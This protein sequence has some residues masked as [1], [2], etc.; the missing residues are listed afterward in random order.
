MSGRVRTSW[1]Y[2][3][4]A[5]FLG[6]GI[7]LGIY[8]LFYL[9][10]VPES[11]GLCL[12]TIV[13]AIILTIIIVAI[14]HQYTSGQ[15]S[16]PYTPQPYQQT[17]YSQGPYYPPGQSMYY[18]Q[19]QPNTYQQSQPNTYQQSQPY[20]YQQ[21]QSYGYQQQSPYGTQITKCRYCDSPLSGVSSICSRCGR[22]N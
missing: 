7:A 19:S 4:I 20:A 5:R 22:N 14:V 21:N 9:A 2:F 15:P 1:G 8:G 12:G 3:R 17:Q 10:G 11:S 6:A 16:R 13:L 18:Q